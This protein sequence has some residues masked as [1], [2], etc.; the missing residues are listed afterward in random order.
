MRLE[1]TLRSCRQ[2]SFAAK[3]YRGILT[4]LKYRVSDGGYRSAEDF[5]KAINDYKED[6]SKPVSTATELQKLNAIGAHILSGKVPPTCDVL[7]ETS[8]P[9][10]TEKSYT[11]L[12]NITAPKLLASLLNIKKYECNNGTPSN[13]GWHS[14]LKFKVVLSRGTEIPTMR[15]I[16][17][18]C[19]HTQL[20]IQ[21]M[22]KTFKHSSRDTIPLNERRTLDYNTLRGSFQFYKTYFS[23]SLYIRPADCQR[24]RQRSSC[25]HRS[26]HS[27]SR[28]RADTCSH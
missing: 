14:N 13:E 21:A 5:V 25:T 1:R 17:I 28:N 6:F 10:L 26:Q 18:R 4:R 7:T 19:M 3:C 23:H 9:V 16:R 27:S 12:K 24:N 8:P 15:M 2:K 22:R 11:A 20:L